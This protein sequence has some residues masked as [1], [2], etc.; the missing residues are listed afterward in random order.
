M[1]IKELSEQVFRLRMEKAELA[2]EYSDDAYEAKEN[3]ETESFYELLEES[4]MLYNECQ[5]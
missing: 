3:D 1:N 4:V 5:L 2:N